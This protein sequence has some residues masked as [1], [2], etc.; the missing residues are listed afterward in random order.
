MYECMVRCKGRDSIIQNQLN[1]S[2]KWG[3][4]VFAACDSK[5]AIL[6]KFEIYSGQENTAGGL[7]LDVVFRL[8]SPLENDCHVT[9]TDHFYTSAKLSLSLRQNT[10][11]FVGTNRTNQGVRNQAK[12]DAARYIRDH[13]IL[14][15]QWKE[16]YVVPML[17]TVH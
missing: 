8:T 10:H 16:K 2:T 12:R 7:A 9:F 4:K 17:I 1:K 6:W 14:Y 15:E 13:S 5:T 3:F 11:H